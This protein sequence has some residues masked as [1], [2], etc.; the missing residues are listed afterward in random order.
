MRRNRRRA[1]AQTK[2]PGLGHQ[3]TTGSTDAPENLQQT[4]LTL[5]VLND[6]ILRT[7]YTRGGM[8]GLD[9]SRMLCLPFKIIEE[10]LT[11]SRMKNASRYW[12]AISLA[13]SAIALT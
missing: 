5:G 9:L 12:A 3:W 7:L 2:R 11:S 13:A 8:L 1:T 4:G 6:L 10:A